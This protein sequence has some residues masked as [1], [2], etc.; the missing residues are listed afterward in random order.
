M[1][2]VAIQNHYQK[3]QDHLHQQKTVGTPN[4]QAFL[5]GTK[6]VVQ[7]GG[8]SVVDNE[9]RQSLMYHLA[10]HYISHG[11]LH[12]TTPTVLFPP[13]VKAIST[14]ISIS[15]DVRKDTNRSSCVVQTD[16]TDGSTIFGG[17]LP[18]NET[19]YERQDMWRNTNRQVVHSFPDA[20]SSFGADAN[21]R[22]TR[23]YDNGLKVHEYVHDHHG[24]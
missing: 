16:V 5:I 9:S 19:F 15:V 14:S 11:H 21:F 24:S 1:T 20:L 2:T 13:V 6:Q 23:L 8:R 3:L 18:E 4:T 22:N 10:G 12:K 17:D 7:V